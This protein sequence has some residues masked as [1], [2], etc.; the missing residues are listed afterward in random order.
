[1]ANSWLARQLYLSARRLQKYGVTGRC[2]AITGGSQVAYLTS[3]LPMTGF[4]CGRQAVMMRE[5]R[6]T[7]I[8]HGKIALRVMFV[9]GDGELNAYQEFS[10]IIVEISRADPGFLAAAI[11]AVSTV[12]NGHHQSP[13]GE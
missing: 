3:V 11:E 5:G 2:E 13:K 10:R 6:R 7:C 12:T 9:D 8:G 1:V 4:Q